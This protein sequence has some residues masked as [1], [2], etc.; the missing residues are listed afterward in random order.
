MQGSYNKNSTLLVLH[1]NLI[2]SDTS[3]YHSILLILNESTCNNS[4]K[5]LRGGNG[6]RRCFKKCLALIILRICLPLSCAA[7]EVCTSA[8]PYKP[9]EQS[10]EELNQDIY[11]SLLMPY[12][13]QEVD[14]YYDRYLYDT[15]M[16]APYTITVL[17]A[18]RPNGYRSFVF[19]IKL[20]VNSYVGP[21]I[22]VGLD[23]LYVKVGGSGDVHIQKF[24]HVKSY[25]LPPNYED[26]IKKGYKNPIP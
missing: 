14:K 15:P 21:H 16:V 22:D 10:K 2:L 3:S 6:M 7:S 23:N 19:N 13:Q 5:N 4:N 26:I 12:I 11:I 20:Q 9:P 18:E 24:E 17:S 1:K 8:F 25:M